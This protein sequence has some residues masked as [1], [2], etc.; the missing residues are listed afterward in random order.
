MNM[1]KWTLFS[2]V[3]LLGLGGCNGSAPSTN[4]AGPDS[5]CDVGTLH[6]ACRTDGCD[7]G[8]ICVDEA[9]VP[10]TTC[11]TLG[12]SEGQRCEP[13]GGSLAC[14]SSC[15]PG[16]RWNATTSRCAAIVGASCDPGSAYSIA[17]ACASM[18][19]TCVE[20]GTSARCGDCVTG[21]E[22]IGTSCGSPGSC[23][24]LG[25]GEW[26]RTC[27]TYE[28]LAYC[29]ACVEEYLE[30]DSVCVDASCAPCVEQHR[31]CDTSGASPIC[32]EC[33]PGFAL[34]EGVCVPVLSCEELGCDAQHR[35]CV[36]ST[37]PRC[38]DACLP[39]YIWEAASES[40]RAAI[41]CADL[42]CDVAGGQ[43]CIEA[44]SEADAECVSG[45]PSGSGW[46][47]FA[48][49]C[50]TCSG[51]VPAS[52]TC[53]V[54]GETGRV[55]VTAPSDGSTCQCETQPNY[56]VAQSSIRAVA[57]DGDGDGWIAKPAFTLLDGTNEYLK[58]NARCDLRWVDEIVLRDEGGEEVL[59]PLDGPLPLYESSRND[60][61]PGAGDI[62]SLG[63]VPLPA[64][65]VN[66]LTKA[67]ISAST[68]TGDVNHNGYADVGEGAHVSLADPVE[69]VYAR[70]SYFLELHDSWFESKG[71]GPGRLVIRERP[72]LQAEASPFAV[73]LVMSA[74]SSPHYRSC[75]RHPDTHYSEGSLSLAGGD[76]YDAPFAAPFTG[77]L[78]HSQFKCVQINSEGTYIN[79]EGTYDSQGY[80]ALL[81]PQRLFKRANDGA[82]AWR[83]DG[84]VE[85]F[86][87]VV[88]S[89]IYDDMASPSPGASSKN[90]SLASISCETLADTP[91]EGEVQWVVVDYLQ[92]SADPD[93]EGPPYVRGCI[94]ECEE[95]GVAECPNYPD[96]W[97]MPAPGVRNEN[98]FVCDNSVDDQFGRIQCGCGHHYAYAE[99]GATMCQRGCA[100]AMWEEGNFTVHNRE[101][102]WM[103][104]Q[105]TLSTGETLSSQS[106]LTL[107]GYVPSSAIGGT[108]LGTP[109]AGYS[110][111]AR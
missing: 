97:P 34:D 52:G 44:T 12:C 106:G 86:P 94:N 84:M 46:D 21:A 53:G 15:E 60:G 24:D 47:P 69:R 71:A 19:R 108:T 4:D 64:E 42:S 27:A 58:L 17:L 98:G 16:Y 8:L 96:A 30:V 67:C 87:A 81:D 49:T 57:C 93:G 70:F 111:R 40:C 28:G 66:S 2:A 25:C 3:A 92:A 73:P 22:P 7:M 107:R 91:G 100:K 80:S 82:L 99:G 75:R 85:L 1:K 79:S 62:P 29:A 33:L 35:P 14:V 56:Y 77:M 51:G 23:G 95:L 74:E 104:G 18:Q 41:K 78:H 43:M 11:A 76:F 72:R 65:A 54:T 39:G 88:N 103:C 68:A 102:F 36:E 5:G 110:I 31:R 20:D 6:C 109:G 59:V 61:A 83:R 50:R 32:A 13:A 45:C 105:T 48:E 63:A 101:G 26:N 55:V 37:V 89:C 38:D 10:A 90:P 9:C